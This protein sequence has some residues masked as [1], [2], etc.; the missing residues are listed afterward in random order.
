MNS[1]GFTLIELMVTIAVL[2]I[3]VGIAAPSI[4]T[5]LANQRVKS[6]A[7]TLVNALKE[8]KAE[9]II[10]RQNVTLSY[11][12]GSDP[13]VITLTASDS[14]ASVIATYNYAAQSTIQPSSSTT[15]VIFE[16]S[17]RVTT[18]RTFTICDSNDVAS[19]RQIVV[20]AIANVT[21]QIGG[22]C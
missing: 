12:N 5:Q 1:S 19:P 15:T 7:A 2:A 4:S 3:I 20:S 17:K 18:G 8:A 14:K 6:T 11:N 10:R 13:R 22:T 9:S 16:P 21:S